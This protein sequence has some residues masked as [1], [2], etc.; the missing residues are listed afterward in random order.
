[1]LNTK[2]LRTVTKIFC[3][4]KSFSYDFQSVF[5]SQIWEVFKTV[6]ITGIH[7]HD[8]DLQLQKWE[9]CKDSCNRCM[10]C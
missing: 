8:N 7:N 3:L 10:Y 4:L 1:M 6:V 9:N 2:Y 5:S